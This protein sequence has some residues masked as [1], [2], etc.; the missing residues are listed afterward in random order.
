MHAG[1]IKSTTSG[2]E[3]MVSRQ[4]NTHTHMITCSKN[5]KIQDRDGNSKDM[6]ISAGWK[7]QKVGPIRAN[8]SNA[9]S[10]VLREQR[11]QAAPQESLK[12]A[13]IQKEVDENIQ[14]I[15]RT[16]GEIDA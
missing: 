13:H 7:E 4:W 3:L 2:G 14:S 12:N 15:I 16:Q 11:W 5:K 10:K 1:A 8:G 6:Q 9:P